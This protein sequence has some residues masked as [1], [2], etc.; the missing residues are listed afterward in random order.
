[1]SAKKYY[2]DNYL[3]F[4]KLCSIYF[5]EEVRLLEKVEELRWMIYHD[6]FDDEMLLEYIRAVAVYKHYKEHMPEVLKYI[7]LFIKGMD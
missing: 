7:S 3:I 6:R 1:M 4:N 2:E 5:Y